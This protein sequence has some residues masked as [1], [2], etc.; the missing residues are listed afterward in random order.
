MHLSLKVANEKGSRVRG[1]EWEIDGANGKGFNVYREHLIT[2]L[3]T[4]HGTSSQK[5]FK[6]RDTK[7]SEEFL[8]ANPD[9]EEQVYMN[10]ISKMVELAKNLIDK[11][12]DENSPNSVSIANEWIPVNLDTK[13]GKA[14][15]DYIQF[16]RCKTEEIGTIVNEIKSNY[17]GLDKL[18]APKAES[19]LIASSKVDSKKYSY[20]PRVESGRVSSTMV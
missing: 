12:K 17:Y 3:A 4:E 13:E 5:Y 1:W 10:I 16:E 20:S 6:W 14:L 8:E 19:S 9:Y 18:K 15:L 2:H 7:P 11:A